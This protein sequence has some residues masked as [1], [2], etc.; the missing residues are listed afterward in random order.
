MSSTVEV[1]VQRMIERFHVEYDTVNVPSEGVSGCWFKAWI[2]STALVLRVSELIS[3]ISAFVNPARRNATVVSAIRGN[4]CTVFTM[5]SDDACG[6]TYRA[7][8]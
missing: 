1:S 6:L 5:K 4:A 8:V 3:S 7:G 2:R